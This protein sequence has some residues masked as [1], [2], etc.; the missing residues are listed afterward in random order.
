ML[1]SFSH[2]SNAPVSSHAKHITKANVLESETL[3]SKPLICFTGTDELVSPAQPQCV[4]NTLD[5]ETPDSKVLTYL[6]GTSQ[7]ASKASKDDQYTG[8]C[9][10]AAR[11]KSKGR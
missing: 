8:K 3:D 7:L 10:I 9:Q 2:I 4:A 5:S 6:A 11:A 1:Q